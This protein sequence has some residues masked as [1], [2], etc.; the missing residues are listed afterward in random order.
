MK[1]NLPTYV[2]AGHR[3]LHIDYRPLVQAEVLRVLEDN[4]DNQIVVGCATGT[5][6]MVIRSVLEADAANRLTVFAAF[7][8]GPHLQGDTCGYSAVAMVNNAADASATVHWWSG[9]S[10]TIPL[11]ARLA[12]RTIS[13]F[14]MVKHHTPDRNLVAFFGRPDSKGTWLAVRAAAVRKFDI[15]AFACGFDTNMLPQPG[16]GVWAPTDRIPSAEPDWPKPFT[17]H[18]APF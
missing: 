8:P 4:P 16:I 5:D 14:E 15:E 12:C 3:S 18:P 2:F 7:G 17:W 1:P 11:I 13:M 6:A 9:G 10:C